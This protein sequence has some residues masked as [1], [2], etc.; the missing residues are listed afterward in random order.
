VGAL[1]AYFSRPKIEWAK[2]IKEEENNNSSLTAST[3]EDK[4]SD[5]DIHYA[6]GGCNDANPDHLNWRTSCVKTCGY[7]ND[8][9][10][11]PKSSFLIN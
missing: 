9:Y 11:N 4:I 1:L 5:C 2:D 10:H 3:C 8:P 7:C 6:N